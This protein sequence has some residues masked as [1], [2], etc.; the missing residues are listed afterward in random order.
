MK[1]KILSFSTPI[2]PGGRKVNHAVQLDESQN[3]G[4]IIVKNLGS[5]G[6]K[7]LKN[8]EKV[9]L[10]VG[11]TGCGKSTWI[12]ALF[13]YVLGVKYED[14]FRFKLVTDE[15]GKSQAHSQTQH[16][17]TYTLHHMD[18]MAVDF[19]LTVVDTPGFG[20]TR[21]I[22]KDKDI[23]QQLRAIFDHKKGGI[24]HIDAVGFV[25]QS[26]AARLTQTQKYIFNSILSLFGNDIGENIFLLFTFADA[27]RP[28][29]LSA[30]KEDGFP[31][32]KF[33]KFNNSAIFDDVGVGSG[34]YQDDDDELDP[35]A[36][37]FD[38]L[39]WDIG[40]KS[41]GQFLDCVKHIST[42][43]LTLTRDV[44]QKREHL[45]K[46]VEHLHQQVT[47]G[48][49]MFEQLREE[50]DML[51]KSL[52]DIE[53][54][55]D[56]TVMREEVTMDKEPLAGNTNTTTCLTC[57]FTC[58]DDCAFANDDEKK[59]C[60]AMDQSQDPPSC[61]YCPNRCPWDMHR[62]L[63]YILK[64][65]TVMKEVTIDD[66]KDR[67]EKATGEKLSKEQVIAK[68][69]D[70]LDAVEAQIKANLSEI[71]VSLER[72][73]E[74]ALRTNHLSQLEYLD[75]L[76]QSEKDQGKPGW[77]KRVQGLQVFR[78]KAQALYDIAQG[79]YDPFAQYR[80][81]ADKARQGNN[82]MQHMSAWLNVANSV[83]NCVKSGAKKV[84]K[85]FS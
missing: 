72:L 76:I 14:D 65:S 32:Q 25:M 37:S 15:G 11:A 26:S 7:G 62:N 80:E 5:S 29:A 28:Q 34:G 6:M 24:D 38:R 63:P 69:Q 55:K 83:K 18:G 3:P 40:M 56:Y 21:G 49:Q 58:H 42:K 85:L 51:Q 81:E 53:S 68:V 27:K 45:E 16:I 54:S 43:S 33:F 8:K 64:Y 46:H 9:I 4:G 67:Y 47:R 12:N 57:N 20:D 84:S 13:N 44:L 50:G 52:E 74:I 82:N 66:I 23:E 19:T 60:I 59:E 10:V 41:F 75:L 22:Q 35:E 17:T 48:I 1:K 31:Y 73:N 79:K 70:D 77:K 36:E 30:V 61:G 71:T 2:R 39:F 78:D